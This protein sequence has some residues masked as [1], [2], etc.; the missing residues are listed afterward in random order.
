[1]LT[2]LKV[3]KNVQQWDFSSTINGLIKWLDNLEMIWE[4]L[5]IISTTKMTCPHNAPTE[6]KV[7]TPINRN[8]LNVIETYFALL[9]ETISLCSSGYPQM[10]NPLTSYSQVLR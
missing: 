1:M 7:Y 2:T 3:D 5:T 9:F 10:L 4:C 6:M 8:F